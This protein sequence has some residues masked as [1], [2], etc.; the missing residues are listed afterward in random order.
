PSHDVAQLIEVAVFDMNCPAVAAVVYRDGEAK[1]IRHMFFHCNGV[2][3]LLTWQSPLTLPTLARQCLH[4]AHIQ[5]ALDDLP[6]SRL[7]F[8]GS[9][10]PPRMT[11]RQ[12]SRAD[13]G[14]D[15]FRQL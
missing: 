15:E 12:L 8:G 1:R 4:L 7:R 3:V 13:S 10:Q 6:G 9:N 14:L 11:R 5:P 2:G